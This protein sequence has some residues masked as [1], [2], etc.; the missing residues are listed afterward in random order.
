MSI[1]ASYTESTLADYM[2]DQLKTI[3]TILGWATTPTDYQEA[4]NEALLAYGE[5]NIANITGAA[6][7]RKLRALARVEVW[8]AALAAVT[9]DFDFSADG[10][11]YK[12]DQVFQ[13][14]KDNLSQATIDALPYDP[15][16]AVEIEE[17]EY[18]RDPYVVR[19]EDYYDL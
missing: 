6:N 2:K 19:D 17:I 14:I 8:K 7:L 3:A 18:G 12:R 13:H 4:V 16:Y 5:T 11:S 9:G 1:P 10:G 15:N